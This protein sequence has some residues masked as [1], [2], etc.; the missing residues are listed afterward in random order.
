ME[1][2]TQA[3]DFL[4][5]DGSQACVHQQPYE[6]V[7]PIFHTFLLPGLKYA[8]GAYGLYRLSLCVVP[9]KNDVLDIGKELFPYPSEMRHCLCDWQAVLVYSVHIG[10]VIHKVLCLLVIDN[11]TQ[12]GKRDNL[13]L[14]AAYRRLHLDILPHE[15]SIPPDTECNIIFLFPCLNILRKPDRQYLLIG[16]IYEDGRVR[17]LLSLH[18]LIYPVLI[19]YPVLTPKLDRSI[20]ELSYSFFRRQGLPRIR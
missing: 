8:A 10:Y 1:Y 5:Q 19:A 3:V 15:F 18:P 11:H 20:H 12:I 4:N 13:G 14:G 9:I 16:N 17:I 6:E 7:L 2:K